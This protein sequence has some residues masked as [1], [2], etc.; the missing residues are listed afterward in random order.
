MWWNMVNV[1]VLDEDPVQAAKYHADQ[2][3]NKMLVE[4]GQILCTA[5]RRHDVIDVPYKSF[6]TNHPVVKWTAENSDN[7]YWVYDLAQALYHEHVARGGSDSH[8]TWS[9]IQDIEHFGDRIPSGTMTP[10]AQAFGHL[11][12]LQHN[13]PVIGYRDYYAAGKRRLRGKPATWS[14]GAPE[15][16][17]VHLKRVDDRIPRLP[18]QR[19]DPQNDSD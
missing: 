5:L 1:F 7:W 3:V 13:D 6:G 19:L 8:K 11:S 4:A 15:W 18:D 14:N 2:H 12:F 16:W 9:K 17:H 10:P